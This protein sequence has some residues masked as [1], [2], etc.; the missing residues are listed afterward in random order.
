MATDR[1]QRGSGGT[2][3]IGRGKRTCERYRQEHRR[4]KNKARRLRA[5]IKKL[6]PDNNMRKQTEARIRELE[7]WKN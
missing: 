6:A 1:V 7:K 5:M 2:A 3:K 4:E